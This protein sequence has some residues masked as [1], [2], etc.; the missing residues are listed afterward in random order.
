MCRLLSTAELAE[1]LHLGPETIRRL[2]R[3]RVIPAVRICRV[4]RFDFEAVEQA[5]ARA[6]EP[7]PGRRAKLQPA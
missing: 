4:L 6:S 2:A 1:Q 3:A 5:L 7:A